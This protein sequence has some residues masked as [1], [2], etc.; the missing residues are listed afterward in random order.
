M[1]DIDF[2]YLGAD[3]P[4]KVARLEVAQ[5]NKLT[6]AEDGPAKVNVVDGAG[7]G[8]SELDAMV[9]SLSDE[10]GLVLALFELPHGVSF[11]QRRK[12]LLEAGADAVMPAAGAETDFLTRLRGLLH[13]S[14]APRVLVIEDEDDVGDWAVKT[15]C[16]AGMDAFRA[17]NLQE[18]T[19]CFETGAL[20]ALVIDRELPDGDGLEF[21][22]KLHRLGIRTPSLFYSG[23]SETAD[24][25]KGFS[26]SYAS[27]YIGKPVHGDELVARV[28]VMLRPVTLEQT[29]IFGPLEINRKDRLVKWRGQVVAL[30]RRERDILIYLAE[31]AEILVPQR[32]LYQD[33]WGLHYMHEDSNRVTV[34]RYRMVNALK[35]H[36][37]SEGDVYSDFVETQEGA[38]VFRAASLLNLAD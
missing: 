24:K 5:T 20:D 13:L 34:A 15:L 12:D 2:R 27:D 30:A 8:P 29:L 36:L 26:E 3:S 11:H 37:S 9:G 33:V 4:A 25:I 35:K 1:A 31:R 19:E 22:A 14:R 38:Y 21:A 18:A 28:Q 10:P 23:H 17:K 6:Y 16:N 32:M 7:L